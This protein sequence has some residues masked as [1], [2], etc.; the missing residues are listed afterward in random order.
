MHL[1]ITR[2]PPGTPFGEYKVAQNINIQNLPQLWTLRGGLLG[3]QATL[4]PHIMT[5]VLTCPFYD[6]CNVGLK[7]ENK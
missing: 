2:E 1:E 7:S 6:W 4:Y 5:I 3:G